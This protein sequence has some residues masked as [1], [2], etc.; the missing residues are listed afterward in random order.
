M[1]WW[2]TDLVDVLLDRRCPG[3]AERAP[4]GR[5][6]CDA[7]DARIPRTG[8]ALCLACLRGDPPG[9]GASPGA[10]SAHGSTH[11]ALAGPAY[12]PTLERILHAFK[13]EGAWRLGRWLAELLPEPPDLDGPIGREYVL[14]PV[15]LHPARR[16]KRGFDQ[17]HLLAEAVSAR[18]GVPLVPAL[19]RVRN[20][21][22]Q[23]RLSGELRR[24]NVHGAF[25][26]TRPRLIR[27]R[28]V[29]LV[30]DVVTTGSTMLEAA[31]A[32]ESAGAAWVLGLAAC[33]GGAGDA[34]EARP[35]PTTAP[36]GG[37]GIGLS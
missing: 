32:L 16:S 8:S 25:R 3:C 26:A 23:A 22:P 11:L 27:S 34:E 15:P 24:S 29:L 17:A 14:V 9:S 5:D 6:V 4:R 21:E 10:C 19:E 33:H 2:W 7:C 28:P 37:K 1:G 18:W 30:D 36:R 31:A 20:H 13:Y 12:E 35:G